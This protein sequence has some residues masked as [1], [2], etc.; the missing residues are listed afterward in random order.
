MK[1]MYPVSACKKFSKHRLSTECSCPDFENGQ[2]VRLKCNM[3]LFP[4][5]GRTGGGTGLLYR[6]D[7]R[8]K[9]VDSG[10]ENSFEFSE[11]IICS[12]GHDIRLFIIY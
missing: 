10:E 1:T 5:V 11:W 8:V 4:R 2:H 7:L 12:T 6:N 9:K 3:F